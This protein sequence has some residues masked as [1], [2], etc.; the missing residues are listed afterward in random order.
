MVDG[1]RDKCNTEFISLGV[2]YVKEGKAFENLVD[3]TTT[4]G[5]KL[6]AN[7]LG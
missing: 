4:P 1:T 2:R 7:S 5:D 6:D 3:I